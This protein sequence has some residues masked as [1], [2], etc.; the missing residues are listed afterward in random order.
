MSKTADKIWAAKWIQAKDFTDITPQNLFHKENEK[1]ETQH[2]PKLKNY[3]MMVRKTFSIAKITGQIWL[4]ISADDYCKIYINGYFVAQGP[5]PSYHFH[6]NYMG[7][8]VTKY[9]QEGE[10]T[11]A[12]H[13]YYQGLIN[14]VWN[15]G[16]YRQGMI[17]ELSMAGGLLLITD[18]S[19]KHSR[20]KEYIGTR[21][22]GY[23]TQFVEDI[24]SRLEKKGW[25]EPGY[26]DSDWENVIENSDDDHTLVLQPIPPVVVYEIKPKNIINSNGYYMI[27][28][29]QEITGFL[30]VQARGEAGQIV[31]ILYGEELNGENVVRHQ[32]RCNCDYRDMWILSG[33]DDELNQYDYKAFRY[34]QISAA[35][36]IPESI[37]A[38][39][40]HYPI[41]YGACEYDSP[42]TLLNDIWR[43][44]ANAVMYGTQEGYLDCPSREKG[45]YL[46]DTLIV[47][48]THA[49]LSGD[50]RIYRK[51]V[52]DFALSAHICPGLMAVAPGSHMQEFADYSL[53]WP[54]L[55]LDYY[56]KSGD[57]EFLRKMEPTADNLLKYFERYKRAD[58]LLEDV[59]DKGN[60]VDWP[61]NLRDNYE[62]DKS[63]K[64]C[65]N[66]LNAFYC[67]AVK[68]VN[69]IKKSLNISYEDKF[70][71]LR[72]SFINAFYSTKDGVFK[73]SE[74][75]NHTALHSNT[76]ALFY[77]L[78]PQE[79][80]PG[81]VAM[82][83]EK[84]F[85]CGVYHAYF[86]LKGLASIGEHDLAYELITSQSERSWANMLREGATT[87]F[88]AWGKEQKWN[89]SLCHP[90][91]CSPILVMIEDIIGLKPGKPGWEEV[92]FNPNIP[93][94]MEYLNLKI[95]TPAG[96]ISVYK[97]D[98]VWSHSTQ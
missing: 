15:S 81:I 25:R 62:F 5:A 23:N 86:L 24:D 79:A 42:D 82:I 61:D 44:C 1:V 57:I 11:L 52:L 18:R 53:L 48:P 63:G 36:V 90:W 21:I 13:V 22:F 37:C 59:T 77:G 3:H 55:L 60:L 27:D 28:F 31:D 84:G 74:I 29:G 4:D 95:K 85:S 80:I 49:Y 35:G 2:K 54:L 94:S 14:R 30:K 56:K 98:D 50:L 58:G 39:V 20:A 8:D 45:Q 70:P 67:G 89:T 64:G 16:D 7:L 69:E 66:V 88:E 34:V 41:D 6:Y 75:S 19:W 17:A 12:V 38:E 32:M 93:E 40:R 46:G 47:A 10:N 26:D 51:A 43:I 33:A 73:D 76:L 78:A 87:C 71:N 97:K 96:L 68:A 65:H 92:S 72:E 91:A 83:R 9:M